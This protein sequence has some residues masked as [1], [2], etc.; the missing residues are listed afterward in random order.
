MF[1]A[2]ER[3]NADGS[4]GALCSGDDGAYFFAGCEFAGFHPR[5]GDH[6]D[7]LRHAGR[8]R[9]RAR[10]PAAIY[11]ARLRAACAGCA[12]L[13]PWRAPQCFPRLAGA[14]V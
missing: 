10:P 3:S 8:V 4:D 5:T 1:S 9:G 2:Y 11:V 12:P 14:R 13:C 7:T 6:S